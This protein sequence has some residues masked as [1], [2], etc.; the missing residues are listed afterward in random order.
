[1]KDRF[2]TLL[3]VLVL[4]GAGALAASFW[5]GWRDVRLGE[6]AG[7]LAANPSSLPA[8]EARL[9]VEVLNGSGEPGAA[10]EV[11]ARLREAGFDVVF[12][13][14]A[15]TFDHAVTSVVNRSG[16]TG[17]AR[18]VAE[19]LGAD[20]VATAVDRELFLDAT[21]VLGSDWRGLSPRAP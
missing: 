18:A 10:R 16:R 2:Q 1:M 11:A 4:M 5:L 20:S 15:R 12:Y 8:G 14:N 3:L 7:R 13:G 21:V 17:A 9:R 6:G 19:A